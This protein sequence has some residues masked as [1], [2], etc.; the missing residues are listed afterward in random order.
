MT[1]G[2]LLIALVLAI[3]AAASAHGNYVDSAYSTEK[4]IEGK[5]PRVKSAL[6]K[7]LPPWARRQY[8]AYSEVVGTVRKWNHFY[9]GVAIR[10]GSV[11]LIVAHMTGPRWNQF[12]L[13]S[14]QGQ[15]CTSRQLRG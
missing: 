1:K 8:G 7:S 6:C 15:G 14:W 9:C 13:T 5:F 12:I 10:D 11:C 2:L 3:P 4:N